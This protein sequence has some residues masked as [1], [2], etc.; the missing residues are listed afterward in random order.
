MTSP[1][2]TISMV[3]DRFNDFSLSNHVVSPLLFHRHVKFLKTWLNDVKATCIVRTSTQ[4]LTP[5]VFAFD[6]TYSR[7]LEPGAL[8]SKMQMTVSDNSCL[9]KGWCYD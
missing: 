5:I 1:L 6:Y 9:R 7:N 4:F 3:L 2:Y 8:Q